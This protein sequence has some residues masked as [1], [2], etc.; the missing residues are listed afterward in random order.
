MQAA[1]GPDELI[2]YAGIVKNFIYLTIILRCR[3]GWLKLRINGY[4]VRF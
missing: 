4:H 1:F 2:K 3:S